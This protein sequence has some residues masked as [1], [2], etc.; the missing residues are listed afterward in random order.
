MDIRLITRVV[1]LAACAACGTRQPIAEAPAPEPL[2]VTG[3]ACPSPTVGENAQI[4]SALG[5]SSS[6]SIAFDG[7]GFALAWWDMRGKFPGISTMRVDRAGAPLTPFASLPHDGVAKDQTLA[8]DGAETHVVWLDETAVKSARLPAQAEAPV[9]YAG[10]ASA[11]AAGPLGAVAWVEK[12]VLY[13]RSDVMLQPPD[14]KGMRL[15]SPPTQVAAGGIDDLR[16]AWNGEQFAVVWSA[17][18]AGGRQIVMQRLSN[19]GKRLGG[20]VKVSTTAGVSRNPEIAAVDGGFAVVWTN[21]KPRENNQHDYYWIF[22]ALVGEE[23]DAPELV[24]QLELNGTADR[25]AIAAAGGELGLAWVGSKEPMGSAVFFS[26]L[27]RGGKPLGATVRVS[28]DKPI[29]C[30]PP[31]I[32]FA[33]DGYGVAW[34]DDRSQTGSQILFSFLKCGEAGEAEASDAGAPPAEPE[35]APAPEEPKLKK[36]FE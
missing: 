15:P 1:L 8:V 34:H 22:F 9:K 6:P 3:E 23:G 2:Q 20:Q 17:S 30:G 18:V 7:Q 32:A 21:D 10:R 19:A 4:T 14:R 12:G 24:R 25:V 31:S 5:E 26:R 27:D 29:T 13:F 16:V 35:A 33:G 11:A 36:L 28:D